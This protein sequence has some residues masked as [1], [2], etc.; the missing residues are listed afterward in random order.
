MRKYNFLFFIY[1][2]IIIGDNMTQNK[3]DNEEFFEEYIKLRE[4]KDNA[5]VIEEAP[6]L[7]SL[8]DNDLSEKK[9]CL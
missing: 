4:E 3:Y 7:F 5:N 9:E 8:I 1:D 6:A 2:I